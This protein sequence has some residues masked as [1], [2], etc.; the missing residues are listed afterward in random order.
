MPIEAITPIWRMVVTLVV[1]IVPVA[2]WRSYVAHTGRVMVAKSVQGSYYDLWGR[3]NRGSK[4]VVSI[5]QVVVLMVA[6]NVWKAGQTLQSYQCRALF[7]QQSYFVRTGGREQHKVPEIGSKR[8]RSDGSATMWPGLKYIAP[9]RLEYQ[10]RKRSS[11]QFYKA[12]LVF[13]HIQMIVF[14]CGDPI[15]YK[16]SMK[17]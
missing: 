15:W 8:P 7:V 5:V 17:I 11:V 4:S 16:W 9:R 1:H 10:T 3:I 14:E 13:L 6:K 2:Y 12:D